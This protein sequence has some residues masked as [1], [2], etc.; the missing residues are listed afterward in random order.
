MT[1]LTICVLAALILALAIP[2]GGFDR[3]HVAMAE[4]EDRSACRGLQGVLR[5]LPQTWRHDLPDPLPEPR[6]V[7]GAEDIG[8]LTADN[9]RPASGPNKHGRGTK[10]PDRGTRGAARQATLSRAEPMR[11]EPMTKLCLVGLAVLAAAFL[12][13]AGASRDGWA[14]QKSRADEPV[15]WNGELPRLVRRTQQNQEQP[16][17]M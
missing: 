11:R 15:P 7:P 9:G 10:S 14:K 3:D 5:P 4:G 1:R 8:P 2:F 16:T 17:D 13:L 6:W 12:I